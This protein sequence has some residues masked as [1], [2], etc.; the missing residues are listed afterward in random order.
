MADDVYS[1]SLA[2]RIVL[3]LAALRYSFALVR[4]GWKDARVLRWF[5]SEQF[6]PR[7]H[8]LPWLPIRYY[9]E[10]F[11]TAEFLRLLDSAGSRRLRRLR[12]R[13]NKAY[14][15]HQP[16]VDPLSSPRAQRL[17]ASVVRNLFHRL[18]QIRLQ[19]DYAIALATYG[20]AG[21]AARDFLNFAADFGCSVPA[22]LTLPLFVAQADT[23]HA[24]V[25]SRRGIL[26]ALRALGGL[27]R[28]AGLLRRLYALRFG[29]ER[30]LCS[31]YWAFQDQ[32][33]MKLRAT[34]TRAARRGEWIAAA[35][36]LRQMA[37]ADQH[38]LLT[39]FAHEMRLRAIDELLQLHARMP[40]TP[41]TARR[42]AI[43]WEAL[44][45]NT[46]SLVPDQPSEE[47][48]DAR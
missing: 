37:R 5:V 28:R 26:S 32:R 8:T 16:A 41:E 34:S 7:W 36:P 3:W 4:L 13:L 43:A 2:L 12:T 25:S 20:S 38:S 21:M 29:V 42:F 19:P 31:A 35:V 24:K 10:F 9:R 47:N 23:R 11:R 22:A 1:W 14:A 48:N 27:Y 40:I 44:E 39:V 33:E 45:N 30:V 17:Q 46:R 18:F 15:R 6:A